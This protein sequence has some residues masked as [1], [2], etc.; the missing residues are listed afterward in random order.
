MLIMTIFFAAIM[1]IVISENTVL[2]AQRESVKQKNSNNLSNN[3]NAIPTG[4]GGVISSGTGAVNG[5]A[6]SGGNANPKRH[7]NDVN[8]GNPVN[9]ASAPSNGNLAT[10]DGAENYITMATITT[11]CPTV[12]TAMVS[13][14]SPVPS[15]S[16]QKNSGAFPSGTSVVSRN[17]IEVTEDARNGPYFDKAASKNVTALLGKTAYLNCRV[18]N[19]GN[20]TMLLQVSWVRHRDIHLLTVGRYTYTSDQR[21]RAIHQPQ[22]EDWILQIKYPQHRDSGIYECQVSTTPHMSHYI[23]LNVV[24][25]STEIIGAPDLYIESGSTINLTCVILNSPEPPAYIF[26]NHNNAIINYDSPRGGV[27]VVTNKGETTTSFLLIKTA[28][29]SDS[30]HY[31][32]NPSN[33]KPKSVTVH[34]LNGEFPAAMQRAGLVHHRMSQGHYLLVY[35]S[36][37]LCTLAYVR[38]Y[39]QL[40]VAPVNKQAKI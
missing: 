16:V 7:S 40:L 23:H 17:T 25:P 10:A 37:Y 36:M 9:N 15:S 33:A 35:L 5:N 32:C 6:V 39:M 21:F 27:S 31:Q 28:R 26:W 19:L 12:A 20:K 22:T 34:V 24:E 14:S 18:K 13:S 1:A 3:A 2:A 11:T 29:P 4:I 8:N 38:W 30:G